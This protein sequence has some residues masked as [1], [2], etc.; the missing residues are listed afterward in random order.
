[1]KEGGFALLKSS[2]S[3]SFSRIEISPIGSAFVFGLEPDSKGF[4]LALYHRDR[5]LD[6]WDVDILFWVMVL[7]YYCMIAHLISENLRFCDS[8]FFH[9]EF[10]ESQSV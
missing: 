1:L 5:I 10:F 6:F 3:F 7:I 8:D 2:V 9:L 4:S